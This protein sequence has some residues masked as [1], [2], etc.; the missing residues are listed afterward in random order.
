MKSI[1]L[2][3]LG[4]V[5]QDLLFD[6]KTY[7]AKVIKVDAYVPSKSIEIPRTAF[8][9]VRGQ[10]NSTYILNHLKVSSSHLQYDKIIGIADIDAY[11]EGLNFVFG[12]AELG[13]RVGVVYLGRLRPE[14]Y[15]CEEDYELLLTRTLKEVLHELGHTFGLLHCANRRCVM[16]FS[17]SILDTDY[18]EANFC[19]ECSRKLN[20][21]GVLV[22]NPID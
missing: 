10:Y 2:Q 3:P 16:T 8:N 1:I 22:L 17:N 9:P 19:K 18:K 21:R 4:L 11:V 14:F 13:G 7:L 12:E 15:G 6:L 5:S 20:A